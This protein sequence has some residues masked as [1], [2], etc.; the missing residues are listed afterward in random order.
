MMDR[1]PHEIFGAAQKSHLAPARFT[2]RE[3]AELERIAAEGREV[4]DDDEA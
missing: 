2:P 3:I 4:E 1:T